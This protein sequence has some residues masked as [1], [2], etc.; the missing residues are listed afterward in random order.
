[1]V[2]FYSKNLLR[3]Q[4]FLAAST[5]R[6]PPQIELPGDEEITKAMENYSPEEDYKMTQKIKELEM[7]IKQVSMSLLLLN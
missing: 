5:F 1:M 6:I 4:N 3:F 7:R 2:K